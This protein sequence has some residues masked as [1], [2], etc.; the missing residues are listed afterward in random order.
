MMKKWGT[1]VTGTQGLPM[2]FL[3]IF[4]LVNLD[5]SIFLTSVFSPDQGNT[6][7]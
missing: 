2:F 7:S 4:L 1:S 3:P 5:F 6:Q